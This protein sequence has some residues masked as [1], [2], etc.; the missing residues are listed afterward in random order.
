M[1]LGAYRIASYTL[2]GGGSQAPSTAVSYLLESN[3]PGAQSASFLSAA[4]GS[5]NFY[6]AWTSTA[7]SSFIRGTVIK[8]NS[9]G[10]VQWQRAFGNS[11]VATTIGG[12][13]VLANGNVAIALTWGTNNLANVIINPS[14]A[15]II[16]QST[17]QIGSATSILNGGMGYTSGST[18]Y[19][20]GFESNQQV[21]VVNGINSTGTNTARSFPAN[22]NWT[23]SSR[24]TIDQNYIAFYGVNSS[25]PTSATQIFTTDGTSITAVGAYG[26]GQSSLPQAIC[27]D[28]SNNI[29]IVDAGRNVLK[30]NSSG[31]IQWQK[32]FSGANSSINSRQIS[33]DG[34][35]LFV[36]ITNGDD[37]PSLIALS[38]SDGSITWQNRLEHNL[39]YEFARTN[40]SI[41]HSGNQI[42]FCTENVND[43]TIVALNVPKDGTGTGTYG[44][45]DYVVSTA[46]TV[47]NQTFTSAST[48]SSGSPQTPNTFDNLVSTA[49]PAFTLT[50]Y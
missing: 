38:T 13:R 3:S 37:E 30:L 31:V 36:S 21:I 48:Q 9:D 23:I 35:N 2:G 44:S 29:Y 5:G 49:T 12:L 22:N 40:C 15:N 8:V 42:Y 11:S 47:S 27:I 4:D 24:L 32:V 10:V 45:Y 6:L 43:D 34:T 26:Q 33:T 18:A 14:N 7:A 28:S 17:A 16:Y 1:P 46:F 41:I 25:T 50:K 39:G 19:A 20:L